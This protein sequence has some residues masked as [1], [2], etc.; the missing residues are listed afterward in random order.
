[1]EKSSAVG[2]FRDAASSA[3]GRIRATLDVVG[4]IFSTTLNQLELCAPVLYGIE[5]TALIP[6]YPKLQTLFI[7]RSY[8]GYRFFQTSNAQ[9][10]SGIPFFLVLREIIFI[11]LKDME[12]SFGAFIKERKALYSIY[13][14]ELCG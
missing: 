9:D 3:V 14:V 5:D 7:F 1:M 8:I 13:E 11:G 12:L 6:H 10:A 2:R 4:P